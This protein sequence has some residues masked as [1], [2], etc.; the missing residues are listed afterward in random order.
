MN[1]RNAHSAI[2]LHTVT[3][4]TPLLQTTPRGREH[5]LDWILNLLVHFV[6]VEH[7][8]RINFVNREIDDPH[9]PRIMNSVLYQGRK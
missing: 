5:D 6:K 2:C 8:I 9:T 4:L 7:P 3:T 1:L